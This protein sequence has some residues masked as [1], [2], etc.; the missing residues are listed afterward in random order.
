MVGVVAEDGPEP[1]Q[2]PGGPGS[3]RTGVLAEIERDLFD[4]AIFEE[5][6]HQYGAIE[7]SQFGQGAL[8]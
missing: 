8:E 5:P 4:A 3:D 2:R 1:V 6:Q 7:G